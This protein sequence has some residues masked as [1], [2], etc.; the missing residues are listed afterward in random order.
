[1]T[2]SENNFNPE[3]DTQL[4]I[5]LLVRNINDRR[6]NLTAIIMPSEVIRFGSYAEDEIRYELNYIASMEGDEE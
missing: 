2:D 4:R 3:D 1:M 5:S 6:A